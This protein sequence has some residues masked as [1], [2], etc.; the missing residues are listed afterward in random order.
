VAQP[1]GLLVGLL[2]FRILARDQ[3]H[4]NSDIH[5]FCKFDS[6]R[7][8][9]QYSH[10]S[11]ATGFGHDVG[12]LI[13]SRF[14]DF[15]HRWHSRFFRHA[16]WSKISRPG[17]ASTTQKQ[18]IHVDSQPSGGGMAFIIEIYERKLGAVIRLSWPKVPKF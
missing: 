18:R 4:N 7:M 11:A 12:H 3:K 6:R 16:G 17:R 14:S 2:W 8:R 9:N 1:R 13:T 5:Y 10:V 15:G